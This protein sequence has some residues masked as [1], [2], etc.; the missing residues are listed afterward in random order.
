[1]MT[2]TETLPTCTETGL[3]AGEECSRCDHKT[4]LEEI[5]ALGHDYAEGQCTRCGEK[6]PDY[7]PEEKPEDKPEEKPEEKPEDETPD[8]EPTPDVELSIFDKIM[9]TIN[10]LIAKLTAWFKNLFAGLKK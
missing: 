7:K 5:P 10:E 4:G 9:K 8:E 2:H 3:T 6:D 1:M